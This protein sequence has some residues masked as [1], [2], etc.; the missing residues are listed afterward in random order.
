VDVF[1]V[2]SH[3]LGVDERGEGG[4]GFRKELGWGGEGGARENVDVFLCV[5][6]RRMVWGREAENEVERGE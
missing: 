4:H 1:A 2:K 3:C 5:A 6:R